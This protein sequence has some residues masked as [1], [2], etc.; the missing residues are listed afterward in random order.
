MSKVPMTHVFEPSTIE[1]MHHRHLRRVS[2][3][4]LGTSGNQILSPASIIEVVHSCTHTC[5]QCEKRN[6]RNEYG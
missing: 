2:G 6:V 4:F 1:N 3:T 5:V